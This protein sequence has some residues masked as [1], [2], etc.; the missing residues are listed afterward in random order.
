MPYSR[1]DGAQPSTP[2]A[3]TMG[4]GH[5]DEAAPAATS[6]SGKSASLSSG[7][8]AC[9]LVLACSTAAPRFISLPQSDDY[10]FSEI[11]QPD[12]NVTESIFRP[13][14]ARL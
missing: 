14:R 8:H 6:P 13:P 5:C 1:S 11:V 2:V 12:S 9:C 10:R 4:H 3:A 7:G